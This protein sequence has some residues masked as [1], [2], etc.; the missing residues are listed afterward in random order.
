MHEQEEIALAKRGFEAAMKGDYDALRPLLAEDISF[1]GPF[2][3]ELH[4]IDAVIAYMKQTDQL[5]FTMP[6]H[7]YEGAWADENRVVLL[8]HVAMRRDSRTVD[9]HT[10]QVV[11]IRDGKASKITMYTSEPEKL[12]EI[13][14]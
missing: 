4:G 2:Q 12:S 10:V 11:E 7:E 3:P 14:S 13:M 8:H 9:T 5:G 1:S 6:Q